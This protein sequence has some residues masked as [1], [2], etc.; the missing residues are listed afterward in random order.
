M[1]RPFSSQCAQWRYFLRADWAVCVGSRN[2]GYQF[3]VALIPCSAS[4]EGGWVKR[5]RLQPF[6]FLVFC[7]GEGQFTNP[8]IIASHKIIDFINAIF[9]FGQNLALTKFFIILLVNEFPNL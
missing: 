8:L 4:A 1:I 7:G 3:L 2:G 5:G 9:G 6:F